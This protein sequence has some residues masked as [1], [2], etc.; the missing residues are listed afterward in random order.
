M[1]HPG[2]KDTESGPD[3]DEDAED[4]ELQEFMDWRSKKSWKWQIVIKGL[5]INNAITSGGLRSGTQK[6]CVN[7]QWE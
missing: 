3:S 7:D 1:S 2:A 6:S 5:V 4:Q